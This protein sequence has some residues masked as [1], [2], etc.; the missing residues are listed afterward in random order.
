MTISPQTALDLFHSG[1]NC[2]QSVLLAYADLSGHNPEILEALSL[3]FGGG[4][5]RLQKTC[6]AVTGAF[7]VIG[8][9]VSSVVKDPEN[10]PEYTRKL[11]REFH[12]RFLLEHRSIECIEII[13]YDINTADAQDKVRQQERKEKFCNP[14]VANAVNILNELFD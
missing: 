7:M 9:H 13:G 14:C 8:L 10:R 12:S 4:M 3:G 1:Y 5:G 11:V 6:G 2:A